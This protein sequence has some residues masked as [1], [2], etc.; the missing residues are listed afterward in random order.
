MSGSRHAVMIA[1]ALLATVAGSSAAQAPAVRVGANVLVSGAN[2]GAAHVEMFL[3]ADPK[4]PERLLACSIIWP[5]ESHTHETVTY[6]STDGGRTWAQ[7]LRTR[8]DKH[9]Q[10]WDPDCF[11]GQDGTA[12][13][14]SENL[15]STGKSFDRLE[16]ALDGGKTG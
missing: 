13:E 8:G 4:R 10:S 11:Y 9:Y 5:M 3:A 12:Y 6:A 14:I 2:A 16:R 7:A 1:A 15:D